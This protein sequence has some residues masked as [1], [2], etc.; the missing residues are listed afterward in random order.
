VHLPL[1][2]ASDVASSPAPSSRQARVTLLYQ[3]I[4]SLGSVER[5]LLMCYLDELSYKQ[6]AS[7]LGI[8]ETN[9]GARLNRTKAKLQDLVRGMEEFDGS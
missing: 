1:E 8:S 6:I 5:A 7:V 4:H 9:V 2:S 3:V